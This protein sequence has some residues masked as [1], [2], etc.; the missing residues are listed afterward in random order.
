MRHG[1]HAWF[2]ALATI[3]AGEEEG[4]GGGVAFMRV[5]TA[6]MSPISSEC[7]GGQADRQ[8]ADPPHD[9]VGETLSQLTPAQKIKK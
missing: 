6:S 5:I 3:D 7:G 9:H 2:A 1:K 8:D 4:R